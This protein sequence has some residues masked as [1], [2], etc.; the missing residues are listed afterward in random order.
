MLLKEK[1]LQTIQ[2]LPAEFSLDELVEKLIVLEKIQIGLDQVKEGKKVSTE[3]AR[4]KRY[5]IT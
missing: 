2:Q 5:D 4:Q 3:E 1:V